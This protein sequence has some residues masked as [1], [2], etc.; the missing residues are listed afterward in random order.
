MLIRKWRNGY[1]LKNSKTFKKK[2]KKVSAKKNHLSKELDE[3]KPKKFP[4]FIFNNLVFVT[5]M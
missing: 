1:D 2:K 4:H 5:D 3:N